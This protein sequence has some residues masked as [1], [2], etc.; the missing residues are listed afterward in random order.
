[1]VVGIAGVALTGCVLM[2]IILK[3][4][5]NSK[6]GI[7]GEFLKGRVREAIKPQTEDKRRHGSAP[8]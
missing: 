2:V 4:G 5:R 7:K 8:C 3:Y 1:M 6:F